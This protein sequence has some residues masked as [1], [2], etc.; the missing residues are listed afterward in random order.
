MDEYLEL[1]KRTGYYD[2]IAKV[3]VNFKVD[4]IECLLDPTYK[5]ADAAHADLFEAIQAHGMRVITSKVKF[6]HGTN[7]IE[8]VKNDAQLFFAKLHTRCATGIYGEA[9]TRAI[10]RELQDMPYTAD[11]DQ[12]GNSKFLDNWK[13]KYSSYERARITAGMGPPMESD[14]REWM[15]KTL[16]QHA[17][18]KGIATTV[19]T[20]EAMHTKRLSFAE[21]LELIDTTLEQ[22]DAQARELRYSSHCI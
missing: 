15:L 16:R 8:E 5:P 11:R 12:G 17:D 4:K 19:R 6:L 13:K 21:F 14:A 10:E 22:E 9:T 20:M 1:T 7:I 2:W 3:R 18:T